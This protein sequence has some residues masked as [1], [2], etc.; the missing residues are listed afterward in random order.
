MAASSRLAI[1]EYAPG[2]SRF[3]SKDI[4][5][6]E[7]D[8]QARHRVAAT[9]CRDLNR[10]PHQLGSEAAPEDPQDLAFYVLDQ[11][12]SAPGQR[13][14]RVS[15]LSEGDFALGLISVH[16]GNP[17]RRMAVMRELGHGR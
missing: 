4:F 14:A 1:V 8:A 6:P 5:G 9:L 11:V 7:R 16:L 13:V 17:A 2:A 15:G 12:E 3:A 10:R